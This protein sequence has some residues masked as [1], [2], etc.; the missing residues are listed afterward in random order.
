MFECVVELDRRSC[1]HQGRLYRPQGKGS[2]GSNPMKVTVCIR[3][4][5]GTSH[6]E[7][8]EEDDDEDMPIPMLS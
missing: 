6:E 5:P 4:T 8:E 7:D 3:I 2:G 1:R